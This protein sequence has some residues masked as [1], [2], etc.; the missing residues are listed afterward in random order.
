MQQDSVSSSYM[1]EIAA[2]GF[3][4]THH[5]AP[6]IPIPQRCALL[7]PILEGEHDQYQI[8]AYP[9]QIPFDLQTT[10]GNG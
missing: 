6:Q 3:R 10:Q 4:V 1:T 2:C 8:A 7:V 9:V 5:G